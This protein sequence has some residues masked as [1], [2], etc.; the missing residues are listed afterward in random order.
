MKNYFITPITSITDA[1]KFLH[2]L[3][4]DNLIFH[5]SDDAEDIIDLSGNYIFTPE[6]ADKV[7]ARMDEVWHHMEDPCK[8]ILDAIYHDNH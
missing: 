2:Q 8:Y 1:Q 6:E 3:N 7:N 4:A 5:P